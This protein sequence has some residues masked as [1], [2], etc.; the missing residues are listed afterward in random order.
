[1]KKIELDLL[2]DTAEHEVDMQYGLETLKGTSDV[3]TLISEA[4]LQ[5][6]IAKA[7]RRTASSSN[8]RTKLKQSFTG[9]FGQRFSIE[10]ED[11]SLISKIRKIGEDVFLEVL[12]YFIMEAL[13]LDSGELSS[14]ASQV[15][16][17]LEDLAD[18][19]FSRIDAPLKRMHQISKYYDYDVK[20]R[21]RKRGHD[22]KQLVKLTRETSSY[23]TDAKIDNNIEEI[24]VVIVRYH[25]KT[26]NGRL[27]I[28]EHNEFYSFGYGTDLAQVKQPLRKKISENLHVNNTI[29]PENGTYIKL[30]V[31]KKCLPSGEIIK[32]LV[33][34]VL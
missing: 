3:V 10:I 11:E 22:T 6:Y 12:S 30:R 1:M 32:Y 21:H 31:K 2:I 7:G 4:I 25:S 20:L 24:D 5:G 29:N 15:L 9:S 14:E 27:H 16:D 13:Y 26:G 33:V 19:L 18:N 17:Q 28:R 8:L 34:G 23:L